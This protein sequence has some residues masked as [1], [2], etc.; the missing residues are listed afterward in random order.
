[1]EAVDDGEI[2]HRVG[3]DRPELDARR[4][5]ILRALGPL[6]DVRAYPSAR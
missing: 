4:G 3:L 6:S 1:M 5:E 2:A